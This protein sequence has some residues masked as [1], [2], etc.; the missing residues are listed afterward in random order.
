[1]AEWWTTS[2]VEL[3][4]GQYRVIVAKFNY[5]DGNGVITNDTYA[6]SAYADMYN[7]A[8]IHP[9]CQF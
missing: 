1:M 5:W 3:Y 9:I 2:T 7:S 8:S 4:Q 6:E